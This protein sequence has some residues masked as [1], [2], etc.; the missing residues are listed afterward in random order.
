LMIQNTYQFFLLSSLTL[1]YFYFLTYSY[2][3]T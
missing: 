2:L 1:I 3:N